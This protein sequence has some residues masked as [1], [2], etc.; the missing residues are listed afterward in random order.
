MKKQKITYSSANRVIKT[1]I[2]PYIETLSEKLGESY[3]LKLYDVSY[4][5]DEII[6][7][8]PL[9]YDQEKDNN[10]AYN[11]FWYFCE[12][13][14]NQF[15]EW[16]H[17]EN[18]SKNDIFNYIGRTSSFYIGDF[19]SFDGVVDILYAICDFSDIQ[20]DSSGKIVPFVDINIDYYDSLKDDQPELEYI[21][22]GKALNDIKKHFEVALSVQHYIEDFKKNQIDYFNEYCEFLEN[23]LQ[24]KKEMK[25]QRKQF[26]K[27]QF[28][29][30]T[31]SAI[32]G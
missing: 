8:Y 31:I 19:H 3:N 29:I 6:E 18:I 12:D 25:E 11:V 4:Y 16:L 20:F 22:T 23:D 26:E 1:D 10:S 5:A 28:C 7:K 17:E 32:V 14:Y 27:E 13:S 21:I 15:T 9:L 30:E 24:Y 2:I